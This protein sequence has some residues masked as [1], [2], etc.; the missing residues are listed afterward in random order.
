[1]SKELAT[2]NDEEETICA[3]VCNGD[4]AKLNPQQRTQYYLM[5]CKAA[6]L[7]P[8][9]QPFQFMN[10]QGKLVLY[11][12]KTASEQLASKHQ[13]RC[14]ILSQ[15]STPEGIRV[16]TVRAVA[17]DGRQTDDIGCV[18]VKG[19]VGDAL[20]NAYMK[21][22]TKAKRRAILS[23]CGLGCNDETEMESIPGSQIIPHTDPVE[24]VIAE[25]VNAA[26]SSG[27]KRPQRKG[28]PLTEPVSEPVQPTKETINEETG[29]VTD[30]PGSFEPEEPLDDVKITNISQKAGKRQDGSGYTCY[31]IQ[32]DDNKCYTTFDDQTAMD[33]EAARAVGR[34][35]IITADAIKTN[36]AGKE[37]YPILSLK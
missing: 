5:R 33:A 27:I 8:R 3:L 36:K 28:A 23:L 24:K 22:V 10:L 2:L 25:A 9:T 13:I 21:A 19:I 18:M 29:E 26:Q 37:Y 17:K 4:A 30:E 20:S 1:M 32:C 35:V 7:D 15:E 14:D 34:G 16:V 6:D 12:L 31:F 11:A